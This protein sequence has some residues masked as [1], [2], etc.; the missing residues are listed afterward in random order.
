MLEK[1]ERP[2]VY[3]DTSTNTIVNKDINKLN[4]YKQKKKLMQKTTEV[5][6]EIRLLRNEIAEI[7]KMVADMYSMLGDNKWP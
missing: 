1:T 3:K 2:D 6:D 7:K 5:S 4:E